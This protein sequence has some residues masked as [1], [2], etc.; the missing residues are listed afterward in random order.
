MTYKL[1]LDDI[2]NPPDDSFVVARS[3]AEAGALII[4]DGFPNFVSFDHDLG[5]GL[6]GYDFAKLL[7]EIDQDRSAYKPDN[8][9]WEGF[10]LRKMLMP[11]DFA[12]TV[13]SANP[14]G[15]DNIEYIL[16]NY[17]KFKKS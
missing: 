11:E 5:E 8:E 3:Y 16:N 2:R 9:I 15:R 7:V 12:F 10:D 4:R 13:H 14:V 17:L 6:T 1:W